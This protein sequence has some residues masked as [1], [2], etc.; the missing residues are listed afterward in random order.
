MRRNEEDIPRSLEDN[1]TFREILLRLPSS[2][3]AALACIISLLSRASTSMPSAT[4][5]RG[6]EQVG[7]RGGSMRMKYHSHML[8]HDYRH[9]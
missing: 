5:S 3:L 8:N 7:K 4:S 2:S 9:D 1:N 6:W